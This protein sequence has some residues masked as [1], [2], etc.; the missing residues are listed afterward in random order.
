MDPGATPGWNAG[1]ETPGVGAT[2]SGKARSRWDE[3]PAGAAGVGATPMMGGA[4]PGW[5]GATP[6]FGVT[7]FG[8]AGMDTPTPSHLPQV[9]LQASPA[10]ASMRS[11]THIPSSGHTHVKIWPPAQQCSAAWKFLSVLQRA[12]YVLLALEVSAESQ[13]VGVTVGVRAL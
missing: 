12:K 1:G 8:G 4:T 10:T 3:T 7:P 6:G 13:A 11:G 5:G 9:G 2:P